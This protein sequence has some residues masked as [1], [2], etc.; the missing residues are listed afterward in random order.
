MDVKGRRAVRLTGSIA[1]AMAMYAFHANES[2][3]AWETVRIH[4]LFSHVKTECDKRPK[5]FFNLS[6]PQ[7]LS[8]DPCRSDADIGGTVVFEKHFME[9]VRSKIISRLK[10]RFA[11][12]IRI[13]DAHGIIRLL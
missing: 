2:K 10:L 3:N 1:E 4:S 13:V 11:L 8:I 7:I 9:S 6:F 12:H 5:L